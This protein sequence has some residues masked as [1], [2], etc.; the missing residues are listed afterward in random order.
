MKEYEVT[1]AVIRRRGKVLLCGR[2][3]GAA[4]ALCYE[5]PGGKAEP[6]ESL[7]DCLRR[8]MGEELGTDVWVL[9]ELGSN[10]VTAGEKVYH[11]HF[12][13]AVLRSGSPEPQPREGQAM[14]WFPTAELDHAGMLPGDAAIAAR[15]ASA[16]KNG[17][18]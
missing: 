17:K 16:E 13:R 4:L 9:D 5:F 2:K 1:A 3:P 10:T 14:L 18:F 11:L 12:L 15:L 6:G 7:A 8:E